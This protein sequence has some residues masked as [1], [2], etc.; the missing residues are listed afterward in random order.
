MFRRCMRCIRAKRGLLTCVLLLAEV[1]SPPFEVTETGWGEFEVGMRIFFHDPV[2]KP[3]S[4]TH[5]LKLHPPVS[6]QPSL[7]KVRRPPQ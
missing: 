1:T 3:V 7:H 4:V 2:Q 6:M 5:V